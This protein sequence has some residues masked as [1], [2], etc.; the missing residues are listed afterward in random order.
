MKLVA[1][2]ADQKTDLTVSTRPGRYD[3]NNGRL[4]TYGDGFLEIDQYDFLD[5]SSSVWVDDPP[6]RLPRID[7][8]VRS[9]DRT[10]SGMGPPGPL[11]RAS[12]FSFL[13]VRH[14][15]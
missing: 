1:D 12:G 15:R 4:I 7:C 2:L 14:P 13:L 5:P 8:S 3:S 11:L 10:T 6:D 9:D